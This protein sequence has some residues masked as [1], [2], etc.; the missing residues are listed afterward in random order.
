MKAIVIFIAVVLAA[1][2]LP[3]ATAKSGAVLVLG[4]GIAGLKAGLDL[5]NAG[6]NVTIL[7]ARNRIGGR[8]DTITTAGGPIELGAQWV[9]RVPPRACG[10][11]CTYRVLRNAW[12]GTL[13]LL[14]AAAARCRCC[15]SNPTCLPD[16]VCPTLTSTPA[17]PSSKTTDARRHRQPSCVSS[18]RA[19]VA[20]GPGALLLPAVC[21]SGWPAAAAGGC[22]ITTIAATSGTTTTHHPKQPA[23][24]SD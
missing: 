6:Y 15:S 14:A 1:A 2:Q 9:S 19:V 12:S 22:A 16:P 24:A 23:G 18:G 11:W 8:I 3:E 4:A 20:D 5:A 21:H 17:A 13:L 7:E 10:C